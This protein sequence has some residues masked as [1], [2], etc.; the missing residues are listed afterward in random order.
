MG[1]AANNSAPTSAA[2]AGAGSSATEALPLSEDSATAATDNN[3]YV[4]EIDLRSDSYH[5]DE[6]WIDCVPPR[7]RLPEIASPEVENE[8]R[9]REMVEDDEARE[10]AQQASCIS[11]PSL[12]HV[13]Q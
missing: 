6:E 2:S 1:A 8:I 9:A 11:E 4:I 5:S 13:V 7:R 10:R 3:K 12:A